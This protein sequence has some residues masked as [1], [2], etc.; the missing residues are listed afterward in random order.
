MAGTGRGDGE[1][2]AGAALI[3]TALVETMTQAV[4]ATVR[5]RQEVQA[6]PAAGVY[7]VAGS[8]R[9]PFLPQAG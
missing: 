4:R 8:E 7:V 5:D 1:E 9:A 6:N 2:S 3:D